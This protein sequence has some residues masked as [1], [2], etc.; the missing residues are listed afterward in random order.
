MNK[1]GQSSIIFIILIPVF[2][3]FAA[4]ILDTSV[5]MH[6]EKKLKNTTEDVLEILLKEEVLKNVT[7]ENEEQV[8]NELK[9][10][11][12]RIYKANEI[13]SEFIYIDVLY[14]G[15]IEI[16]NN[17]TYYSFMNS[18]F[19]KGEGKRQITIEAEGYIQDDKIVVE[20]KEGAYDK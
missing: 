3:L 7:Y 4:I 11:A 10:K 1:L 19:N 14:N 12:S 13:D 16:S 9:E 2:L 5:N 15:G 18:L 8:I 17:Y 20:F 6:N